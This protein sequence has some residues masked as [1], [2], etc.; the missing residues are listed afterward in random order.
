MLT[1]AFRDGDNGISI[2]YCFAGKLFNL[3][4]LQAKSKV[5]TEAL[6]EFPFADDMAKG[7]EK[8]Q[9][10][11]NQVFDSIDSCDLT[12]SIKKPGVVYQSAPGKHYKEP[13]ITEKV[14][15][16]QVETSSLTLEAHWL[17]LCI[18]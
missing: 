9:K 14:Q 11:M 7:E 18:W 1:E 2:R 6:D 16:L 17:E 15:R 13:T 4:G 8:M 12:I 5:Q 3:R 10:C